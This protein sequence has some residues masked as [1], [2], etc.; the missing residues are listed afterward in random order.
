[1]VSAW[2]PSAFAALRYGA[3]F[4]DI[5]AAPALILQGHHGICRQS[6]LPTFLSLPRWRFLAASSLS[7]AVFAVVVSVALP[8]DFSLRHPLVFAT[9]IC[10]A[11]FMSISAERVRFLPSRLSMKDRLRRLG[12]PIV[13]WRLLSGAGIISVLPALCD[14]VDSLPRD[15]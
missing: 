8:L 14:D 15:T 5:L 3:A 10:G 13:V 1:M 12:P 11:A 9:L 7:W 6:S 4:V 2:R